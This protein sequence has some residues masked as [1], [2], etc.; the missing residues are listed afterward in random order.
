MK[1][2]QIKSVKA[3]LREPDVG[4]TSRWMRSRWINKKV[5]ASLVGIVMVWVELSQSDDGTYILR[6]GLGRGRWWQLGLRL[7]YACCRSMLIVN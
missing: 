4:D 7:Q 6:E 5:L 2:N 1:E 3:N